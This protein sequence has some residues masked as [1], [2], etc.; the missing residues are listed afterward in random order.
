[1]SSDTYRENYRE[2]YRKFVNRIKGEEDR[3]DIELDKK[4]PN[5]CHLTFHFEDHTVGN[6]LRMN[7]L[8]NKSVKFAG[9]KIPH[10]L[11]N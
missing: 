5:C 11:L 7:L 9:Y 10:P 6:L 1:M 8:K 2:S 3:I 4:L